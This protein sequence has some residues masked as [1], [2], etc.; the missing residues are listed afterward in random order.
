M[1]EKSVRRH[2]DQ[3]QDFF[4]RFFGLKNQNLSMAYEINAINFLIS[5]FDISV[6]GESA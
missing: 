6:K 4:D 3:R 2:A 1:W 5:L